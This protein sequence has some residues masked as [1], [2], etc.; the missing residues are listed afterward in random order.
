M[1]STQQKII[2]KIE[3]ISP[4]SK[5][6]IMVPFQADTQQKIIDEPIDEDTSDD[7]DEG[8]DIVECLYNGQIHYMDEWGYLYTGDCEKIGR[9]KLPPNTRGLVLYSKFPSD[10][11]IQPK[12]DGFVILASV[13]GKGQN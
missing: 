11:R 9:V 8:I 4:F 5:E 10:E 2:E 1:A 13:L 3:Y 7:D 12:S 6:I